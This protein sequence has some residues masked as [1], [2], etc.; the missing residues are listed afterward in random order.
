[1]L[2]NFMKEFFNQPYS[3]CTFGNLPDFINTSLYFVDFNKQK[4]FIKDPVVNALS[5]LYP[6]SKN[7]NIKIK[8]IGT[9]K[10][11]I[12]LNDGV[13]FHV[14]FSIISHLNTNNNYPT[15]VPKHPVE[16]IIFNIEVENYSNYWMKNISNKF[17]RDLISENVNKS[18]VKHIY[19]T[20]PLEYD[21]YHYGLF[22]AN[23]DKKKNIIITNNV[24][25]VETYLGRRDYLSTKY[26]N[27]KCLKY[28]L[29]G[30]IPYY[31]TKYLVD[32]IADKNLLISYKI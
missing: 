3:I 21:F 13:P 29:V 20:K 15:L 11:Q 8:N 26:F 17:M 6:I 18:K 30:N 4:I 1:M 28:D 9:Y 2:K 10:N 19:T 7:C 31:N 32:K 12:S 16:N 23:I 22:S 14:L 5:E 25:P 27:D 24:C